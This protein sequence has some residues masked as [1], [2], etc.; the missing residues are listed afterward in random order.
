MAGWA[1]STDLL[2][3]GYSSPAYDLPYRVNC[4]LRRMTLHHGP[5]SDGPCPVTHAD[6]FCED[7]AARSTSS[8][9]RRRI[10]KK[11]KKKHKNCEKK[12]NWKC[13][14]DLG[15]VD[16]GSVG[17]GG[18]TPGLTRSGGP[19]PHTSAKTTSLRVR[20]ARPSPSTARTKHDP[21]WVGGDPPAPSDQTFTTS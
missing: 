8:T 17:R 4:H 13:R 9:G 6:H 20:R 10:R 7:T 16:D 1:T 19:P 11:K 5:R 14:G 3:L 21:S 15:A 12:T 18:W 2:L